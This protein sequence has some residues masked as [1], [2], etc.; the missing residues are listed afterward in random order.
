[1]MWMK[2]SGNRHHTNV[3]GQQ[4]RVIM[5]ACSDTAILKSIPNIHDSME[6]KRS[7]TDINMNTMRTNSLIQIIYGNIVLD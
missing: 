6:E 5:N 7:A 2:K 1:M 4:L 3:F